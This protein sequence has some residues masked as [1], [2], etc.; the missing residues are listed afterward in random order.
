M[1][2]L[3]VSDIL[4]SGVSRSYRYDPDAILSYAETAAHY[5]TA[6]MFTRVAT[7]QDETKVE[8]GVPGVER[9]ILAKLRDF[10]RLCGRD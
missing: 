2:S 7:P 1:G 9:R 3:I 10:R 5:D 8:S 4:R 6:V